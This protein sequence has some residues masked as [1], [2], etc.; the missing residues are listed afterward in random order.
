MDA[1]SNRTRES[2]GFTPPGSL[3]SS[4]PTLYCGC[5]YTGQECLRNVAK[6]M[7]I[8]LGKLNRRCPNVLYGEDVLYQTFTPESNFR[9]EKRDYKKR[10]ES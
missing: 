1:P 5:G 9:T 8:G 6:C 4:T 10:A 3:R 7:F 2:Q